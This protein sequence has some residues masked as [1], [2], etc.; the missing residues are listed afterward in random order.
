MEGGG[1]GDI[2]EKGQ[3]SFDVPGA[4]I[5]K[6][7]IKPEEAARRGLGLVFQTPKNMYQRWPHPTGRMKRKRCEPIRE[8]QE[9]G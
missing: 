8:G 9:L 5:A 2:V 1:R 4:S 7:R 3:P 6:G